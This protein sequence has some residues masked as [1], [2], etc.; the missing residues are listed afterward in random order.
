[1]FIILPAYCLGNDT[2]TVVY[3]SSYKN[4]Q[5][6]R[7]YKILKDDDV[8]YAIGNYTQKF[9][10]SNKSIDLEHEFE[11]TGIGRDGYVIGENLY[12]VSRSNGAGNKYT[13]TPD[14]MLDFEDKISDFD[15]DKGPFDSY[16][17]D[18]ASFIDET[19][20][21]C[22]NL[23]FYSARLSSNDNDKALLKK[24]ITTTTEAYASLW[25]NFEKLNQSPTFIPVLGNDAD[26]VVSMI[27]YRQDNKVFLGVN[28]MGEVEWTKETDIKTNEW[29]H[30]K[31]HINADEVELAYREKECGDWL[32]LIR[33]SYELKNVGISNL[34]VGVISEEESVVYIDDYYYHP[35]DIDEVSYINGM[36]SIYDKNTLEMKSQMHLNIR[37][38][39]ISVHGNY[40]YLCCL[41]GINIYDISK[42]D[43][44]VLVGTHRRKKYAEFH[45]SDTFEKDGHVYLVVST[46]SNG[47][48]ILDVT[49]PDSVYLVKNV[50]I[51]DNSDWGKCFT[52]DV[53]CQYPYVYSTFTVKESYIFTD[54]DHRG[55]LCLDLSDL[56][57]ISQTLCEIPEDAKSNVTTAD[58][59]PN[60]ITKYKDKLVLN[61]STRGILIFDIGVSGLPEYSY[62]QS[63]PG[64]SAANAVS[65]FEDGTLFVGDTF[66]GK[67]TQTIYTD[68]GI[69]WYQFGGASASVPTVTKEA[70]HVPFYVYDLCGRKVR[71]QV[72]SLDGLPLGIYIVNGK[73]FMKK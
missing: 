39:S 1:M 40:L 71:Q 55:C 65:A 58:N 51:H 23:G 64:N 9:N 41:R 53:V 61:N 45:G 42:N 18:G 43:H 54:E 34:C 21:P 15:N 17:H 62:C 66:S 48:D 63:L 50:P 35:T 16:S 25:V 24:T 57:D 52:F 31:I 3:Q 4:R 7:V 44:P 70:G 26:E 46:Y 20:V 8:L 69:Y 56:N 47:T 32:S 38:N 5:G 28:V 49:I 6:S 19:G 72:T 33:E 27:A 67:A 13:K 36:F 10:L 29:Y 59:Q 22:P 60:K 2:D 11:N 37:P 14:V 68:Y 73:T 30:L 12:V